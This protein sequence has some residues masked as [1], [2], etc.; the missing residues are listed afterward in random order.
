LNDLKDQRRLAPGRPTLDLLFH[1]SA[2]RCLLR[3]KCS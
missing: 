1:S 2:Y 3:G